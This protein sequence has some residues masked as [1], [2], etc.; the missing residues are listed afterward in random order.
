MT[1]TCQHRAAQIRYDGDDRVAACER[2][3]RALVSFVIEDDDRRERW[4]K[5]TVAS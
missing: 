4:S 5:W 1:E 2:C 3:G